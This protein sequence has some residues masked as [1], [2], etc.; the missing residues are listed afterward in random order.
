MVIYNLMQFADHI[1]RAR[2]TTGIIYPVAKQSVT[3]HTQTV[4]WQLYFSD[5]IKNIE[6]AS[7]DIYIAFC[8]SFL[9]LLYI[10]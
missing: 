9:M 4:L 5:I 6:L 10:K 1:T 8:L 3:I 2:R 7:T